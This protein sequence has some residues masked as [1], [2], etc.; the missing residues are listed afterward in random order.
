MDG[1][2]CRSLR[3]QPIRDGVLR[4]DGV[5]AVE[6]AG[7]DHHA[8][9][10]VRQIARSHTG[11]WRDNNFHRQVVLLREDEVARIVRRDAHDRAGAV[12]RQHVIGDE[13]RHATCVA[14]AFPA[15]QDGV[16]AGGDA[17]R[18]AGVAFQIGAVF[19]LADVGADGLALLRRADVFGQRVLRR[20]RDERHAEE[21]VGAGGEDG[22]YG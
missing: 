22:D 3:R 2:L 9:L 7:V 1:A 6:V 19:R 18:L 11:G 8:S 21:G 4:G 12:F 10:S 15:G 20:Q 13:D 14:V 16:S 17:V 5:H